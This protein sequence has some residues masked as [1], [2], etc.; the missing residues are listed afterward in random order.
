VRALTALERAVR[1]EEGRL[2]DVLRVGLVVQDGEGVAVDGVHVLR[3]EPL[4]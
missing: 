3:V 2:G 1:V 4:E